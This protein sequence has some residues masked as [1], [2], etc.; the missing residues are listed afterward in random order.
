M[1]CILGMGIKFN[2]TLLY[3]QL[4]MVG[5]ALFIGWLGKQF[6]ILNVDSDL[7]STKLH[8][9]PCFPPSTPLCLILPSSNG[10]VTHLIH[11]KKTYFYKKNCFDAEYNLSLVAGL[12]QLIICCAFEDRTVCLSIYE[13]IKWFQGHCFNQIVPRVLDTGVTM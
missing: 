5:Q 6:P 9:H 8:Q 4:R 1:T 11:K 7:V 12:Y 3:R 2:T 13:I 10:G